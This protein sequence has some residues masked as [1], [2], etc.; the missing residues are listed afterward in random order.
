MKGGYGLFRVVVRTSTTISFIDD[1]A[2][3]SVG[4]DDCHCI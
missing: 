2:G 4:L 3:F 1:S